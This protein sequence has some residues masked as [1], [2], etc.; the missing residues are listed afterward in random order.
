MFK[1]APV[2]L[3]SETRAVLE[4]RVRAAKTP[5]RD[6]VRARIVLLAADGVPSR[7][8]SQRVGMHESNVALWRKRFL[9]DGLAGLKD[10]ARPGR[11]PTYD[12]LDR[13]KVVAAATMQ[14]DPAEPEATWTY[15]ALT[16]ALRDEV[17][18]SRSQL[19]RILDRLD[20]KPHKVQGWLNRRDD[21]LFWER[22][23]DV[24]GLYLN[25]PERALVFSVDEKTSIQ[26]KQRL[27]ETSPP[28]AGRPCRREFEYRRHGTASLLAALDVHSGQVLARD[29]ERNNSVTFMQFLE[30]LDALV[31]DGLAIHLV[32]DNGSSH[33]SKATRAWLAEHPRFVAHYTPKH[34]SWVNQVELFFSILTRKVLRNGNFASRADLVTKLMTFIERYNTTAG[35]F[36]W[37]YTGQPLTT[38]NTR[39]TSAR[40][41]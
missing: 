37:T 18:I 2:V 22:V 17:G 16:E 31:E 39:E 41:H 27:V 20:V 26:A 12:A 6:A 7:Q 36:A 28:E 10:A 24:C 3:D 38:G 19:W 40:Q 15:A 29:I 32:L 1:A 35:P 25:P 9:A 30:Q 4:A 34:A 8:I 23:Q 13:L 14:R 33:T 21:P 5:Q 11:P